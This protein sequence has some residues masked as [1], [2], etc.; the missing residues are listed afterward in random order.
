[1]SDRKIDGKDIRPCLFGDAGAKSPH[2]ALCFYAGGE[3]QAVRSGE[4]K[5]HFAHDYL[6][7]AGP[8]GRNG[9]PSN[10][11]NL[12]PASITQSGIHGIASRHGYEVAHTDLALFNMKTDPGE[13]TNV[14]DQ[15]PE[16][17]ARLSKLAEGIRGELG[18]ELTG[19]MGTEIRAAGDVA[20]RR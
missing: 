9:K 17:V 16:V 1:L 4:W 18:D 2:D 12:K 14:A 7:A 8:P 11:E 3:L 13:K 10:F 19:T 20:V 5:L 6:T 15:H